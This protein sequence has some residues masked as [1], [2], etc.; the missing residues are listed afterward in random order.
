MKGF[1]NKKIKNKPTPRE[2]VREKL[3]KQAFKYFEKGNLQSSIQ[4]YEDCLSK[5]FKDPV[6]L[7]QY[8]IV[9]F[10]SGHIKKAIDIF[11]K[12]IKIY[13]Q[14]P[15]LY[16]NLSNIYKSI[17]NLNYAENL[18]KK[19]L[20]LNP[21]SNIALN[22]L[23]GILI[24]KKLFLEAKKYALL[25][26]NY[27]QNNSNNYYNLG[28]IYS[29]LDQFQDSIL[30]FK[31]AIKNDPSNYGANLNLG[32]MLLKLSHFEE[33]KK[34]IEISLSLKTNSY[35]AYFN[36]GQIAL[37][38]KKFEFAENYFIKSLSFC[39]NNPEVYKFL[40]IAQFMNSKDHALDSINKSIALN[41]AENISNVLKKIIQLEKKSS[42]SKI[43]N[44]KTPYDKFGHKPVILYKSVEKEILKILYKQ[45]TSDLNTVDNSN[46][47]GNAIG[48]NYR[49][50]DN[51]DP[52]LE[53]LKNDLIKLTSNYLNSDIF[54]EDSFFRI[55]E[56]EGVVKKHIH[57]DTL[58]KL[59]KLN[60]YK[61]KFSLVYYLIT[62]DDDCSE[63]GYL[64]FHDPDDRI[65]PQPG[66][67]ILFPSDRPHSVL[68]N[69]KSDRM[70]LSINFYSY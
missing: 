48:S 30:S 44:F 39:K 49:L 57:L 58:D 19:S 64:T 62:G 55:L 45:N 41:S 53:L 50:F 38:T 59:P 4:C 27:D 34:Y 28:L 23:T 12:S 40:G 51:Y 36:L 70:I 46:F 6:I 22:N 33:A 66:M 5:G 54:I 29:N 61:Y 14:E 8:G 63:P 42:M 26:I 69:G 13:P 16:I 52:I 37:F 32:A 15:D 47:S 9:L 10:Q 65:L 11:E 68:Y 35:E 56:G 24:I 3:I 2:Y 31:K 18:I 1:G 20:S 25:A 21:N 17:G 60:L 43:E 67:I 7:S